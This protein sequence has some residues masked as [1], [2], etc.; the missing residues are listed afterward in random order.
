MN[1]WNIYFDNIKDAKTGMEI[2]KHWDVI[3]VFA[4]KK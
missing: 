2:M 3:D 4:K 1:N